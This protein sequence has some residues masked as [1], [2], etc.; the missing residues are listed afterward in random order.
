MTAGRQRLGR[1]AEQRVA[2]WYEAAGY[3]VVARNWRCRD[4]ELDLVVSRPGILVFVEVKARRG[5]SF[6]EAVE[7]IPGWK[8]RRIGAMA[9]DYL[10]WTNRTRNVCR[11]DVVAIDRIGSEDMTVTVI[12]D[13]FQVD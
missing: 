4:G 6:G 2:R 11:F 9:L 8:R 7:S 13:A 5:S 12:E 1:W 10:A 3:E